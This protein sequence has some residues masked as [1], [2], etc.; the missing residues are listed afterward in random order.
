MVVTVE[1]KPE[2][3]KFKT[4]EMEAF[5]AIGYGM[6]LKKAQDI[7]KEREEKPELWPYEMYEK[8]QAFLESYNGVP[9]S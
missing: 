1:D 5:L 7:I 8:A 9:A 2:Q 3:I 4:P 6:N